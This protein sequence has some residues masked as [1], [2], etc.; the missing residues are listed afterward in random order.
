MPASPDSSPDTVSLANTDA[1]PALP[2]SGS[3]LGL[4]FAPEDSPAPPP[5]PAQGRGAPSQEPAHIPTDPAPR[6]AKQAHFSGLTQIRTISP[7]PQRRQ[8]YR[9]PTTP[10]EPAAAAPPPS[11]DT[12]PRRPSLTQT[13]SDLRALLKSFLLL[14][15][16]ALRRLRF[17]VPSPLRVIARFVIRY[18]A[19]FLHARGALGSNLVYDVVAHMWRVV[20]TIF[21]R[22]IRSRGAWKIPRS[23]EGAVIFVVGPHHNQFLDPLLLMSEVKRESGRRISFLAAAKSMDRAFVGLAS[24]L[25]Q[26]IP[27]A[28]A[29]D[30]AF[31]GQGTVSLSPSDPLIIVGHG[32]NF[33][34][35][36]SK[37]RSQLLLPRNLGSSTAEVVEVVSD[38]ELKLKKEFSKKALDALKEREGGVAF[39]VL[40]HVD[41]S[42]MYSAVYQKLIDGGCIGIFPEGGSHDRTDLLPLKAGVSIMALGAKSAHPDL[43]LQIVPVGLSYFHPHK[44][45]SRAVVEFGSPIEIPQDYVSEFE[46]GGDN[47]KKA[48][49]EVMELIVDGLKSVTV[50]A[51]DYETLM[52]IQAARRLY[53]PPG[54]NLTIG[55]VVELNKRFIVGYE[56]YKD[57][58]RIKE[59]ERGV[60]EYNTLLRYM[61]LKDHQVE[62]GLLSVWGVLALPGVVLNAPIFIAAKLISRQ[63][64]KEAL[65]ASTVKIAG[66]DVLAT[67]KVLVALAGAPS[68]YTIYAIN[69]VVLAHKLGLPYKYKLAAPFATFAGLPFIGVAA[70]KFGEVGMDVYKS[71]RPLLLSLIPGKKPELKRLRHMRETL[72]LELNELVDEL[73][74][75]VFED[76]DSRR[77]I[78]STDVGVRR[79]SAQGKFLQHPL[80]WVDELLFG[81]GWSQSMAHPADRKVKSMLPETSGME[82]DMDGGFTDGQG[83]GS[84]YASGYTTEDAP[85]YDEVIHILNREQG[86]PDSPLPSPRPGLYRR[87]SRQRSRSQLNLAAMSPVTS[88]T[89]LAASTSVQDGGEGAA[90]RR[91]RQG[92]GDAQE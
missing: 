37:P 65:A 11:R 54:T 64:A 25:M 60:R 19:M 8:S 63:K 81:S 92:S 4:S 23:S 6:L 62:L 77:I 91:T 49:G 58:P 29:Q 52:L 42:S 80:N 9:A 3:A 13:H 85:D 51:P 48:I 71:M 28:R 17:L 83:G 15:P 43:K 18:T 72:A 34:K 61:G 90:R 66:R 79:E 7:V 73:A 47:K 5:P 26:S 38:T 53:R 39:K 59:L 14:V 69:A 89:P 27:V 67:W 35:D 24:R 2:S 87:A 10:V 45:R 86:R 30:Y 74:P 57:D 78:P 36:F 33:T 76:F 22:E 31:A 16:P 32:T 12:P 44:F 21:F 40:P 41:Q 55:Q 75:T 46:K 88:T 1:E 82:S 56:V 50:R 68:L 70:L 84:G 20:I